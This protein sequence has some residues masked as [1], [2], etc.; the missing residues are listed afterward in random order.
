[1]LIDEETRVQSGQALESNIRA[2][3]HQF[4]VDFIDFM[5]SEC[6]SALDDPSPVI[7]ATAFTLIKAIL[8]KIEKFSNWP[9]VL[10]KLCQTLLD[11]TDNSDQEGACLALHL[12][13]E[14]LPPEIKSIEELHKVLIHKFLQFLNHTNPQI[15][16]QSLIIT[17]NFIPS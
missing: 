16:L 1:M 10:P 11:S 3:F 7:R 5:K 6:I 17:S 12:A 8:V 4:R 13:R 15:R 9:D 14:D 2:H